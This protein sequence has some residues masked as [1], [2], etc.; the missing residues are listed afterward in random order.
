MVNPGLI[1]SSIAAGADNSITNTMPKKLAQDIE[2]AYSS[3]HYYPLFSDLFD[4]TDIDGAYSVQKELIRIRKN[5]GEAVVGYKAG[6]TTA[7]AQ[8]K[9]G[10]DEPV[11]GTLFKSMLSRPQTISP[12]AFTRI[13]IEPEIGYRVGKKITA[14]VNDAN[15]LKNAVDAVF[16]VIEL[17]DAAFI[18]MGLSKGTDF[19]AANVLARKVLLGQDMPPEDRDMNRVSVRVFHDGKE[20]AHG[21]GVNVYGNQWESLKWTVNNVLAR[22]GKIEPGHI[23]ITGSLTDLIFGEPGQYKADF[24]AFGRIQFDY[25]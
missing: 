24:G 17:P 18:D 5:S 7:A 8:K 16:P 2:K 4:R 21:T 3:N 22:G 14:P 12:K 23:F 10:I 9:F 19:I 20:I 15:T 11:R 25:R 6:L 1:M 13:I